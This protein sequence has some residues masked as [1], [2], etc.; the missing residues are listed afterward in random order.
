MEDEMKQQSLFPFFQADEGRFRDQFRSSLWD[1]EPFFDKR[2]GD[3]F[4]L[5]QFQ[6]DMSEGKGEVAISAELPGVMEGDVDVTLDHDV[7]TIGGEKKFQEEKDEG[8]YRMMERRY[9]SFSRSIR[10]PFTPDLQDIDAQLKNGVLSLQ[11]KRPANSLEKKVH[12][13]VKTGK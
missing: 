8:N 2:F 6:I 1:M 13:N 9:G 4:S 10:L 3:L 5:P 7:L 11:V 12:V